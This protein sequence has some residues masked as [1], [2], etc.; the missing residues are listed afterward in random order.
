MQSMMQLLGAAWHSEHATLWHLVDQSNMYGC[1]E[2]GNKALGTHGCLENS[3]FNVIAS[4]AKPRLT[5][6]V[7]WIQQSR[8]A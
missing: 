2:S 7:M 3:E 4:E 5:V 1:V 6:Q 8:L